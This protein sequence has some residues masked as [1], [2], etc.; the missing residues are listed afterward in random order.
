MGQW[1]EISAPFTIFF[2]LTEVTT[3]THSS[4]ASHYAT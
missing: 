4:P 1:L 2:P 3:T